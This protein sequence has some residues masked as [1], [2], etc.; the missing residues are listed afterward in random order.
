M[1]D[2]ETTIRIEERAEETL[3]DRSAVASVQVGQRDLDTA[4]SAA[5]RAAGSR[6]PE[7]M[8]LV[9]IV[10]NAAADGPAIEFTGT[11]QRYSTTTS[12]DA[13]QASGSDVMA[14]QGDLLAEYVRTLPGREAV[15]MESFEA[16]RTLR[17]TC[18][19]RSAVFKI[20]PQT[21][22]YQDPVL[23]GPGDVHEIRLSAG[24]FRAAAE[25]CVAT[26]KLNTRD[27]EAYRGVK[28][29][30]EETSLQ[31]VG[32][33]G[34]GAPVVV[35]ADIDL[36]PPVTA[37]PEGNPVSRIVPLETVLE[38]CGRT[39]ATDEIVIG[40]YDDRVVFRAPGV[41]LSS[42]V[43]SGFLLNP[44]GL[45]PERPPR[46]TA[47]LKPGSLRS[48]VENI[49]VLAKHVGGGY[50]RLEVNDSR[51]GMEPVLIGPSAVVASGRVWLPADPAGTNGQAHVSVGVAG[52]KTQ[53]EKLPVSSDVH[54]DIYDRT[55]VL[56]MRSSL[57]LDSASA[58]LTCVLAPF[59]QVQ[60]KQ[61]DTGPDF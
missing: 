53:V 60:S 29:T 40:M 21:G 19:G 7:W 42:S 31:L 20:H 57:T 28:L 26:A 41:V 46:S 27:F 1:T 56:V 30:A 25:I 55:D 16:P 37:T 52:L 10:L 43:V 50:V 59:A 13:R 35:M 6:G 8:A 61:P 49:A 38:M 36:V 39:K 45:I 23:R 47:V 51:L 11:N 17:V 54:L 5:A 58:R 18:A 4:L 24:L 15:L 44:A 32:F 3:F 2:T 9:R 33:S 34:R 22:A 48:A 14:L 12:V